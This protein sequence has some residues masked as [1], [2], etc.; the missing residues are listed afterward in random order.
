MNI[1]QNHQLIFYPQW[2]L[3][4]CFYSWFGTHQS[5]LTSC[6]ETPTGRACDLKTPTRPCKLVLKTPTRPCK[7]LRDRVGV[8]KYLV[9]RRTRRRVLRTWPASS[10]ASRRH[11]DLL[12]TP[13]LKQGSAVELWLAKSCFSLNS[14]VVPAQVSRPGLDTCTKIGYKDAGGIICATVLN[15]ALSAGLHCRTCFLSVCKRSRGRLYPTLNYTQIRFW[16]Q[17]DLES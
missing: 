4:P 5:G 8:S 10:F 3:Y 1:E 2:F 7:Y 13:Q 17:Y 9:L 14:V 11:D 12:F 6:L 15:S 16:N